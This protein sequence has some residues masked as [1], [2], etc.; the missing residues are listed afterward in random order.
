MT[1]LTWNGGSVIIKLKLEEIKKY[2][3]VS[4]FDT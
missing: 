2:L 4:N 1:H 3:H